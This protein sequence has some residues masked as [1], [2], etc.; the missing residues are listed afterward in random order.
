MSPIIWIEQPL[1]RT[2]NVQ[3]NA[4]QRYTAIRHERILVFRDPDFRNIS[5]IKLGS[6]S[7]LSAAPRIVLRSSR[8]NRSILMPSSPA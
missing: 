6:N 5:S 4:L 8:A 3:Q 7:P 2:A 1:D